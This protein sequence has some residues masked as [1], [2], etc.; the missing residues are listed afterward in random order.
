MSLR[1]EP[2]RRFKAIRQSAATAATVDSR[3]ADMARLRH[4]VTSLP[5]ASYHRRQLRLS[6]YFMFKHFR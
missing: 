6:T 5:V 1:R 4:Y 3:Y 2:P